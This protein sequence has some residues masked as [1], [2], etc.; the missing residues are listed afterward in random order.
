MLF[1]FYFF[2]LIEN[3]LITFLAEYGCSEYF[4]CSFLVAI[5]L[6]IMIICILLCFDPFNLKLI[7]IFSLNGF[8][9]VSFIHLYINKFMT[10]YLL[11]FKHNK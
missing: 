3:V 7:K 6:E 10:Q 9:F 11:L 4:F 8:F 5:L 2:K 1:V